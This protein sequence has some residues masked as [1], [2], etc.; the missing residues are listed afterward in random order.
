MKKLDL[1]Q[2]EGL[3]AASNRQCLID[4]MLTGAGVIVGAFVGGPFGI[5][6][7]LIAGGYAMNANKCFD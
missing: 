7:A 3:C 1:V 2:M 6:G 5:A 4:G